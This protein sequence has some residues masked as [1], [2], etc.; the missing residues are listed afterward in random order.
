MI[1][2]KK[3]KDRCAKMKSLRSPGWLL[4]II[5]AVVKFEQ[6]SKQIISTFSKENSEFNTWMI[7]HIFVLRQHEIYLGLYRWS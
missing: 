4:P 5:M 7:L 1:I 3:K 2:N 6:L